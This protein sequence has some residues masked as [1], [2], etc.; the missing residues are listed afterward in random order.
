MDKYEKK[1]INNDLAYD[2]YRVM[3]S[4]LKTLQTI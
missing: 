3:T 2:N 1:A 4:T